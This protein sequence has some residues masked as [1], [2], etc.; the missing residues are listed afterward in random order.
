MREGARLGWGREG[1]DEMDG[2]G[3]ARMKEGR[4][5]WERHLFREV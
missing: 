3:S 5:G 4:L 2:R 1:M